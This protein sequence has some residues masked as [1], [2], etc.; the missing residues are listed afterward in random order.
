M[1]K[2]FIHEMTYD[3]EWTAGMY[4]SVMGMLSLLLISNMALWWSIDCL[5]KI[6]AAR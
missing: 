2:Q 3:I 4:Y 1:I 5:I 6:L